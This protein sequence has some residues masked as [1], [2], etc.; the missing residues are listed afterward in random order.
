MKRSRVT[1]QAFANE[2]KKTHQQSRLKAINCEG[3]KTEGPEETSKYQSHTS[4]VQIYI[5]I[6]IFEAI[7][8][9]IYSFLKIERNVLSN[10]LRMDKVDEVNDIR[11]DMTGQDKC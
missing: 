1:R 4:E 10:L 7:Y 2:D 8:I 5:Y 3:N 9:Y 6:H 11:R